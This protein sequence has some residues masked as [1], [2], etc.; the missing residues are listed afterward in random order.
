MTEETKKPL[1]DF[2]SFRK[3]QENQESGRE[4][5]ILDDAGRKTNVYFTIHGVSSSRYRTGQDELRAKHRLEQRLTEPTYEQ[6][7]EDMAL[8]LSWCVSGWRTG[9]EK[10]IFLN[11]E[12]MSHSREN[13]ETLLKQSDMLRGQVRMRV[14]NGA[15][16]TDA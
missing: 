7:I 9:E 3:T 10:V 11:G 16:F 15:G 1:F 4:F 6:G 2:S 12:S 8:A 5:E 14:D 13:V